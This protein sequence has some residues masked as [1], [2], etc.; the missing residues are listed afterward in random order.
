MRAG[1]AFVLMYFAFD[2]L[3]AALGSTRGEAG[4]I[5]CVVI[6]ALAGAGGTLAHAAPLR[7]VSSTRLGRADGARVARSCSARCSV[8]R[9]P[10]ATRSG[11]GRGSSRCV[12]APHG[13]RS[14][15]SRRRRRRRGAVSRLHVSPLASHAY[16]LAC[17]NAIR[18]AVRR[19]SRAAALVARRDRRAIRARDG[20]RVVVPARVVVRAS[21]RL[22]LARRI[23]HAVIQ[24]GIKVLVDDDAA[25]QNL[26]LA[27]VALGI[28][29]P[30]LLLLL[31]ERSEG[32]TRG[33]T[34]RA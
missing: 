21:A 14:A 27:W 8:A 18:S 7:T 16:V 13:S 33:S 11:D 28:V 10:T 17:R 4:F 3:A 1:I 23:L 19:C 6:V 2:R 31:R 32:N 24:S 25:F 20:D 9:V 22:D 34:A 12:P 30:W 26:A 29:A 5:V 15:C